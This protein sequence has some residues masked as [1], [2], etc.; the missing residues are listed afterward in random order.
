M[1]Y[2]PTTNVSWQLGNRGRV[3]VFIDGN[4]LFYVDSSMRSL[5]IHGKKQR[6]EEILLSLSTEFSKRVSI[7]NLILVFDNA[8]TI[9]FEKKTENGQTVF[10]IPILIRP[11]LI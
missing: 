6:V 9:P 1:Q 3:A 4:N 5:S 10:I 11:N 7:K 8:K 2:D